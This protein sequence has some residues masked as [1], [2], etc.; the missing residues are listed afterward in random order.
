MSFDIT[1]GLFKDK[2]DKEPVPAPVQPKR[3]SD[4]YD[5]SPPKNWGEFATRLKGLPSMKYRTVKLLTGTLPSDKKYRPICQLRVPATQ[6]Q[7][8]IAWGKAHMNPDLPHPKEIFFGSAIKI[9]RGGQVVYQTPAEQAFDMY[10]HQKSYD[11]HPVMYEAESS[12]DFDIIY[13]GRAG[14]TQGGKIPLT[15]GRCEL[16]A[17]VI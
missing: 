14:S 13:Y 1:F 17:M 4:R 2:D 8:I 16:E 3:P 7:K 15:S 12:G 10:D 11:V 9:S 5:M 6:G